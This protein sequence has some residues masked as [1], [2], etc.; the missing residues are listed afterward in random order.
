MPYTP[1]WHFPA[2][3]LC[4]LKIYGIKDVTTSK[5]KN[6]QANTICERLH[7][8]ISIDLQAT[9]HHHPLKTHQKVMIFGTYAL[10]LLLV[11]PSV[12]SNAPCIALLKH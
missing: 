10:L 4:M 2:S 7:Q 12:L 11:H 1:Y 5:I 9:L 3:L 6:P 8:L